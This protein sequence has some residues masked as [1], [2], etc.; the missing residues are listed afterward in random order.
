[1]GGMSVGIFRLIL[2]LFHK[3]PHCG[4]I[5]LRPVYISKVHYMY[6]ALILFVLS[7]AIV[8]VISLLTDPPTQEMV[9]F[10]YLNLMSSSCTI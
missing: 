7:A 9:R 3:E 5:D 8:V 4:E 1:M 10:L 2:E 6:V